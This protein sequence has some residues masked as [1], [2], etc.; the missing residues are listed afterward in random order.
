MKSL[1]FSSYILIFETALVL[2]S[3]ESDFIITERGTDGMDFIRKVRNSESYKNI[4]MVI[5][6]SLPFDDV[7][8]ELV[9][10]G[11]NYI[12]KPCDPDKLTN[13]LIMSAN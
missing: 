5:A 9:S 8:E 11:V 4:P 2:V 10:L 12:K 6:S 3:E 7:K 13:I 1:T